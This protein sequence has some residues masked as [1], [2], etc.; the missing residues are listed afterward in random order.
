MGKTNKLKAPPMIGGPVSIEKFRPPG[1]RK[2]PQMFIDDGPQP[3]SRIRPRPIPPG[4]PSGM[5]M[6]QGAPAGNRLA[7][8]YNRSPG[9]ASLI[10]PPRTDPGGEE[11][12]QKMMDMQREMYRRFLAPPPGETPPG[13]PPGTPPVT[14]PVTPPQ[15][16][17]GT[18][19]GIPSMPAIL[20]LQERLAQLE[21]RELPQFD[22]TELE[23]GLAGLQEQIGNIPQFDPTGLQERLG[24]LE[25]RELPQFDP[26]E[27]M[28]RLMALENPSSRLPITRKQRPAGKRMNLGGLVSGFPLKYP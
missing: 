24:Q 19:P 25:N 5:P 14:P 22:P 8:I 21:N 9:L 4:Q 26:S 15:F 20:E 12:R 11:D 6:V 10:N 13:T 16:P 1:D 28:A 18:P 7:S 3:P 2:I 27:I 23:T 17:P